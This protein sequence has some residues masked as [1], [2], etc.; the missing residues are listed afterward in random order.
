M[1]IG[2]SELVLMSN[3]YTLCLPFETL[4]VPWYN[5]FQGHR[6]LLQ[7]QYGEGVAKSTAQKVYWVSVVTNSIAIDTGS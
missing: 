7:N 6:R 1:Q 5:N 2:Y 4:I 3:R